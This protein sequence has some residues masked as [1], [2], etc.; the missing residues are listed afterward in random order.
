MKEASG[1]S[2][3]SSTWEFKKGNASLNVAGQSI[4]TIELKKRT[5]ASVKI[6]KS[7]YEIRNKGYWNPK[8]VIE[9]KDKSIATLNRNFWD[10]FATLHFADESYFEFHVYHQPTLLLKI[11]LKDGVEICSFQLVSN[12]PKSVKFDTNEIYT[13]SEKH[14]LLLSLGQFVFQGIVKEYPIHQVK[15]EKTVKSKT[16]VSGVK[17]SRRKTNVKDGQTLKKVVTAKQ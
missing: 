14:L 4:L 12:K 17:K 3:T 11:N 10:T 8:T 2:D 15:A 5:K 1:I 7:H 9:S 16:K 6:G 13:K